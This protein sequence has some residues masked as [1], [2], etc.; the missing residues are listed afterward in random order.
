MSPTTGG[1]IGAAGLN[2]DLRSL[3]AVEDLAIQALVSELAV[4]ALVAA[5]VPGTAVLI[6]ARRPGELSIMLSF[7]AHF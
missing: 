4:A 3:Q 2:N 6:V 1:C 7:L 5:V